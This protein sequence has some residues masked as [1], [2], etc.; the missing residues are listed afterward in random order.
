MIVNMLNHRNTQKKNPNF[1]QITTTAYLK[2][3]LSYT[4]SLINIHAYTKLIQI[5]NFMQVSFDHT[6]V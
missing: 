4:C 6:V 5:L 1:C 2:N 3:E